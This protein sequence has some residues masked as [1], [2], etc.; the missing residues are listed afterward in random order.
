MKKSEQ[1]KMNHDEK[2]LHIEI[3][4]I[5][6]QTGYK[7]KNGE[8]KITKTNVHRPESQNISQEI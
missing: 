6:Y 8:K 3:Q 4:C 5:S 7:T 2:C 1:L